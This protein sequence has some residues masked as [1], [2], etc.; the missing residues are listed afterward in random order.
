MAERNKN[1]ELE[2]MK[3]STEKRR[4]NKRKSQ[5]QIYLMQRRNLFANPNGEQM[6]QNHKPQ[7][8]KEDMILEFRKENP[9]EIKGLYLSKHCMKKKIKEKVLDMPISHPFQEP[10]P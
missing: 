10:M 3:K 1:D 8:D 2:Q 6:K 5:I 9:K 7:E 4:L